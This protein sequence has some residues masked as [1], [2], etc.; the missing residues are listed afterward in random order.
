MGKHPK[1]SFMLFSG[2]NIYQ[3]VQENVTFLHKQRICSDSIPEETEGRKKEEEGEKKT[4]QKTV[5]FMMS[6]WVIA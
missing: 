6:S 4:P 5:A 1:E 3:P 2:I